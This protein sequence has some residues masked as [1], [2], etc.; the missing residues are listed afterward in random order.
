MARTANRIPSRN[1]LLKR[2]GNWRF[3]PAAKPM[4]MKLIM[5]LD[6]MFQRPASHTP[7]RPAA[8][9]HTNSGAEVAKPVHWPRALAVHFSEAAIC[10]M[11]VTS[12]NFAI[13][14]IAPAER[15]MIRMDIHASSRR[16]RR[17]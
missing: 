16:F 3:H 17:Q 6:A 5:L 10:S 4:R 14:M 11:P 13:K 8:T 12:P 1:R 9:R 15:T 7:A 2:S